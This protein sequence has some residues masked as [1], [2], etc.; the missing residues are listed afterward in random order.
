MYGGTGTRDFF[1]GPFI[2][3]FRPE[4]LLW[5]VAALLEALLSLL[6]EVV[7][8]E[9]FLVEVLLVGVLPAAPEFGESCDSLEDEKRR[10]G[11]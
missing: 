3:V 11:I 2:G 5:G 8:V 7:L 1:L 10:W 6:A 4:D 9:A